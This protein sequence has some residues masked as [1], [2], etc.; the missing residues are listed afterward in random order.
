MP[1]YLTLATYNIH[2]GIGSD[3]QFKPERIAQVLHELKADVVALQEVEHILVGEQDFLD[4]LAAET[5][6]SRIAGPTLVREKYH[7]GN[8][9]L[10]KLPIVKVNRLDLSI[11]DREPRGAL[12]IVLDC[13]GKQLRVVATHLGLRPN[14][15]RHQVRQLLKRFEPAPEDDISVLMGDLNE[16]FLWGRILHW[17]HAHFKPTPGYA[18]FPARWPLFALDRL[19]V[20]PKDNLVTLEVHNS[21]LA[22]SASDHLPLKAIIKL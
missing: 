22:R 4:Y 17:L 15:R 19:W 21:K 8:A 11:P 2:S 20:R 1:M 16:W 13:E 14:E 12:D 7:Y 6:S 18:T 9:L 5:H 3:G 10:T